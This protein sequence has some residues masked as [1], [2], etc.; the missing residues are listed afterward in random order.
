V[1]RHAEGRD[2]AAAHPGWSTDVPRD[3]GVGAWIERDGE[4]AGALVLD[5]RAQPCWARGRGRGLAG[6]VVAAAIVELH[7][8]HSARLLTLDDALQLAQAAA[9]RGVGVELVESKCLVEVQTDWVVR[10]CVWLRRHYGAPPLWVAVP[11][12]TLGGELARAGWR[13][14]AVFHDAPP[15]SRELD[16]PRV[17]WPEARRAARLAAA[18]LRGCW[19]V[20]ILPARGGAVIRCVVL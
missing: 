13:F 8:A 16:S 9:R 17:E 14:D 19:A 6:G 12:G 5:A 4:C 18:A 20:R 2:I 7:Q 3:L 1:P 11:R 10:A 15:G